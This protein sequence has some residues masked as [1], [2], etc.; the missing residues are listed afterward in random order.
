MVLKGCDKSKYRSLLKGLASQF[1][2]GNNQYPK[3]LEDVVSVLDLHPWD[4]KYHENK[5]KEKESKKKEKETS[6]NHHTDNELTFAQQKTSVCYCCGKKGH[7]STDCRKKDS[8]QKSDWWI[9]KAT[10]NMQTEDDNKS[11]K[12]SMNKSSS[13]EDENKNDKS[14][15]S[16]TADK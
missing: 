6:S 15:T 14:K 8:I 2:M 1:S 10:Q 4:A 7:R 11:K 3:K 16:S 13:I 12:K 5:K 9:H